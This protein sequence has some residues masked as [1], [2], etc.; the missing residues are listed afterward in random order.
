LDKVLDHLKTDDAGKGIVDE[1]ACRIGARTWSVTRLEPCTAALAAHAPNHPNTV[2]FQ[3][4][5]AAARGN[6]AEA[7]TLIERARAVSVK[8]EEI[9]QMEK[10]TERIASRWKSRLGL[11]L[12]LLLAVGAGLALLASRLRSSKGVKSAGPSGLTV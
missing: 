2:Y 1:L 9:R 8:P 12:G 10:E 7:R 6:A 11:T 4:A 5:L 3:W